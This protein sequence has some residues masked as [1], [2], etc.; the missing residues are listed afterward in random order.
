MLQSSDCDAGHVVA[1][2]DCPNVIHIPASSKKSFSPVRVLAWFLLIIGKC[3][4]DMV[5]ITA[6]G[7]SA[8]KTFGSVASRV[9][10]RPLVKEKATKPSHQVNKDGKD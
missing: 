10:S 1:C 5:A 7:T 4:I 9:E 2:P 8:N 6:L 3:V